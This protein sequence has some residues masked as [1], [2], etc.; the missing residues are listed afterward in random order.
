MTNKTY[1]AFAWTGRI[2]LP[3]S[4]VLYTTVGKIW[5]LP[6]TA[7]IPATITAVALFINAILKHNSDVFFEDKEI[8]KSVNEE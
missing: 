1:D 8:V 4:A 5:G 6:Y 3:A 7:E 2:L